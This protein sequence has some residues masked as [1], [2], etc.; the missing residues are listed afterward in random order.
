MKLNAKFFTVAIAL[1]VFKPVWAETHTYEA[2]VDFTDTEAGEVPYYR[3]NGVNA[4]AINAAI[5]LYRDKFARATLQFEESTGVYDVTITSLGEIDG[6]G[7]F[8]FLVDGVVVGSAVNEP[9]NIDFSNQL[10]TFEGISIPEGALI[11]VESVAV[12]N[13]KVP[14]GDAYAYARGRWTTLTISNDDP[15]SATPDPVESVNLALSLSADTATA[16]TGDELSYSVSIDNLSQSVATNPT[17]VVELA[18]GLTDATGDNCTVTNATTLTCT[19]A[20]LAPDE[21]T[22]FVITTI[23]NDAG[24][25]LTSA[26]VSADQPDDITL[27]NADS[28]TTVVQNAALPIAAPTDDSVDLQLTVASSANRLEVGETVSYTITVTNLHASNTATSPTVGITMPDSLRFAAS[29]SC[30]PGTLAIL[31]ELPELAPGASAEASFTATAVKV[32]SF[33]QVLVTAASAQPEIVV[34]NNEIQVITEVMT[35]TLRNIVPVTEQPTKATDTQTAT[36][37]DTPVPSSS[38]SGG[39]SYD[40][41]A[42][43]F[44]LL[45]IILLIIRPAK[46]DTESKVKSDLRIEP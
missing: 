18:D 6:D 20:E 36:Q 5:E 21:S 30:T 29:D 7:E 15:D 45:Q 43:L 37:I 10:H 32:N 26:S 4:L 44:L 33:S 40:V 3:H 31:C 11:G 12:S 25:K 23:V 16:T 22:D 24:V 2:L 35:E 34:T 39:G 8:R 19:L 17:V 1:S 38:N 42:L 46:R 41:I 27:N 9:T 14:E 13:G 28:A